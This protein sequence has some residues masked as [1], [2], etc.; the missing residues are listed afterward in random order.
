MSRLFTTLP[1]LNT[2]RRQWSRPTRIQ[3]V[4]TKL[5]NAMAFCAFAVS[6]LGQVREMLELV[7]QTSTKALSKTV[8]LNHIVCED[9]YLTYTSGVRTGPRLTGPRG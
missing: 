8:R 2:Q 5:R 4:L 7:A 6:S 3:R 9:L 1:R